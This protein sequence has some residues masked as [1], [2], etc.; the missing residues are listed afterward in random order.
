MWLGD[1]SVFQV[2][3]VLGVTCSKRLPRVTCNIAEA[4]QELG[5]HKEPIEWRSGTIEH[6]LNYA[7]IR[8][9]GPRIGNICV[10]LKCDMMRYILFR[11]N[12]I[13]RANCLPLNDWLEK[14]TIRNKLQGNFNQTTTQKC[15]WKYCRGNVECFVRVSMCSYN[16]NQRIINQILNWNW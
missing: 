14:W 2:V 9:P 1:Q 10:L 6:N 8:L 15:I 11:G 16:I 7:S 4:I 5:G 12:F 13:M 3:I